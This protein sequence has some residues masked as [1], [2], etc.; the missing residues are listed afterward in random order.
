M[1]DCGVYERSVNVSGHKTLLLRTKA[2]LT[3]P[4]EVYYDKDEQSG[5]KSPPVGIRH[6]HIADSDL[7]YFKQR[8]MLASEQ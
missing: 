6:L 8:A 7:G 1:A 2:L 4:N 5:F 3:R